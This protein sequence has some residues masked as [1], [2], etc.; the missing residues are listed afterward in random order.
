MPLPRSTLSARSV[1]ALARPRACRPSTSRLGSARPFATVSDV[2]FDPSSVERATDEVDVCIVGG[3]PAG[4]SAA[5]RLK[6]LEK[7]RGGEELRVVVLEKGGEVG[8][9]WLYLLIEPR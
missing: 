6:Q 7:E 4:L 2:E 9:W 5:I 8:E 3:G 1:F